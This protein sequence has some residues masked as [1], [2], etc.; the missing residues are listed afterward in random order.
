M[1]VVQPY[2]RVPVPGF[3]YVYLHVSYLMRLSSFPVVQV[4][5]IGY[6]FSGKQEPDVVISDTHRPEFLDVLLCVLHAGEQVGY[7][8]QL[9]CTRL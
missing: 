4:A 9:F 6:F 2:C 7:R 5:R 1:E 8:L 3:R